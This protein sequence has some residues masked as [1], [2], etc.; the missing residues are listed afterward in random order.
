MNRTQ[1]ARAGGRTA[2]AIRPAR[3]ADLAALRDFFAGLSAQ[4][5]YLRFFAPVTPGP[6]LLR[7]LSGGT[8]TT[9]AVVATWGEVII[10]H[11]MAA[12][13][14]GPTSGSPSCSG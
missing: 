7:L 9:Y 10:G 12:D 14:A 11:A 1:V 6:A 13:R 2:T 8:G 3:P 4:T 5:R